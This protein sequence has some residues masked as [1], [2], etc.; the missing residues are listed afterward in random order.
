[1][2]HR[3]LVVFLALL[4]L[5]LLP[6]I[7]AQ[8][9]STQATFFSA[10]DVSA[11]SPIYCVQTGQNGN[12]TDAPPIRGFAAIITSGSSTTVTSATASTSAFRDVVVGDVLFIRQ[13]PAMT[14]TVRYVTARA[15]ADSI[16]I[17]SA[18]NIT[19]ATMFSFRHQTCGTAATSGQVNAAWG[20]TAN[21]AVELCVSTINATSI[22]FFVEGKLHAD[23]PSWEP[24]V[25]PTYTTTG[26]ENIPINEPLSLIRVGVQVNTDGGA[27]SV[28]AKFMAER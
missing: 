15:S 8:A 5:A 3:S 18:V 1:M 24:L 25:S 10:Y 16:T 14:T 21:K 2:K 26:C 11:T 27:Q 12:A 4:I 20:A 22:S 6:A 28:T 13:D 23:S 17:N 7:P 9:Q 19:A